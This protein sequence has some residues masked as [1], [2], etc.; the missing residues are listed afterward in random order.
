MLSSLHSLRTNRIPK[1]FSTF[2]KTI[3]NNKQGDNILV[4][5][6]VSV[7]DL[8][9]FQVSIISGH[10]EPHVAYVF[11]TQVVDGIQFAFPNYSKRIKDEGNYNRVFALHDKIAKTENIAKYLKSDRRQ[12]YSSGIFR[13]YPELDD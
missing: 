10:R 13:H 2:E 5:K 6:S 11:A 1:F 4:G 8:V 12:K 7:A 9:L 3:E